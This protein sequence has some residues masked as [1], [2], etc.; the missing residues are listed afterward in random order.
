M[1][2]RDAAGFNSQH[3]HTRIATRRYACVGASCQSVVPALLARFAKRGGV[4][5]QRS[6]QALRKRNQ[7]CRWSAGSCRHRRCACCA[8]V[9]SCGLSVGCTGEHT[10]RAWCAM[11]SRLCCCVGCRPH[12]ATQSKTHDGC[13]RF[14]HHLRTGSPLRPRAIS[15]AWTREACAAAHEHAW[16]AAGYAAA[17]RRRRQCCASLGTLAGCSGAQRRAQAPPATIPAERA[18]CRARACNSV[19]RHLGQASTKARF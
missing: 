17:T 1:H 4:E 5:R 3:P 11:V 9:Q 8:R 18:A 13:S 12:H 10:Q 7:L 19:L 14:S 6:S 2:A 16:L 15:A